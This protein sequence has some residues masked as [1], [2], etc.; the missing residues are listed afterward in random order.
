MHYRRAPAWFPAHCPKSDHTMTC[1]KLPAL[2]LA[3]VI[4]AVVIPGCSAVD[5][6]HILT[7]S[8][9]PPTDPS[10]V[11]TANDN[12][13][14]AAVDTVWTTINEQYYDPR[15]NG[16]DWR[17]VRERYQPQ[18]LAAANDDE[19]WERLD[20]M[21]GELRDAHTRVHSP[22]DAQGMREGEARS[23]GIGFVELDKALV[24]TSVHGDSDAYFA[25]AR[26]GMV[27]KTI[28]GHPALPYYHQLTE[29][30]R[31]TSTQWARTRG[32]QRKISV[33][34]VGTKVDM[35]FV[36][37]D[38]S[39]IS[40]TLARRKFGT[41]LDFS[42]RILPSGFGYIRFSNFVDGLADRLESAVA[43]MK[44]TPAIIIDLRNNG[45]G[46]AD[47]AIKLMEH[48]FEKDQK[49]AK[50]LTRSGKGLSLFFIE[51]M[52]TEPVLH[53]SGARAYT[54]PV[55]VLTNAGSASAS[56]VVAGTLQDGGRITVIGQRTCGCL[57]GFLGYLELPGGGLLAYS[58]L[59]YAT[60]K[61]R[62]IEGEGVTPDIEVTLTKEDYVISRDRTL[63]AAETFL[64]N[65]T[66]AVKTAEK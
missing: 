42:Q 8:Y 64:R 9:R 23:L 37:S 53:G 45:G 59:G 6:Y 33:G 30:A 52:S 29:E 35:T 22:K 18:L 14:L 15:L 16:V 36:R 34:D 31:N 4:C 26:P 2:L 27:I 5:P 38:G 39:E 17:A 12:W 63:E 20:K 65:K 46:S 44:D 28:D 25:G 11:P 47:L 24:L 62:R 32:A 49:G 56:E 3:A 57:L 54:K 21:T 58:Q 19:F 41:P 50:L 1:F 40:A 10:P 60:S 13:K 66:A 55:V 7:R 43:G 61:G 48:F 51:M